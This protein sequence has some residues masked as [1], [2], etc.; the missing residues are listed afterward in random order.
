MTEV[1][2]TALSVEIITKRSTPV[3]VRHVGH[4]AR[5]A[6][7]VLDRLARVPLHHRHVLVRRGVE[8]HGRGVAGEDG[9]HPL[10]VADVGHAGRQVEVGVRAV[11]LPLNLEERRL[12]PLDQHHLPGPEPGHL[13]AQLAADA[14]AGPGDE[15]HAVLDQLLQRLEVQRHRLAPEQVLDGHV[16]QLVELGLPLDELIEPRHGAD[17]H[18]GRLA[19]VDD[20][21]HLLAGRGRNGDH[22][23]VDLQLARQVGHVGQGAAHRHPVDANAALGAVVVGEAHRVV[24]PAA[25]LLHLAHQ[26]L[27]GVARADDEDAPPLDLPLVDAGRQL[28]QRAHAEA[29]AAHQHDG[30][31]PVDDQD[32]AR[33]AL[34]ARQHQVDGEDQRGQRRGL[35]QR[36][37]VLRPRVAPHA[38]EQAQEGEGRGPDEDVD[39]QPHQPGPEVLGGN[40]ELEAQAEGARHREREQ[41]QVHPHR[42]DAAVAQQD[43]ARRLGHRLLGVRLAHGRSGAL[44]TTCTHHSQIAPPARASSRR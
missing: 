6:H 36:A 10:P 41:R 12:R 7:V 23:L 17:G 13:P 38:R 19:E 9:A 24:A 14:A 34:R 37:Q 1:G 11:Q 2:L 8:H 29:Q 42:H 44:K 39:G 21:P 32:G 35:E 26:H 43:L 15:H 27:A 33:V 18:P 3:L 40:R 5:A 16:A 20:V 25:G 30:Q 22:D 28:P 4:H 31:Q